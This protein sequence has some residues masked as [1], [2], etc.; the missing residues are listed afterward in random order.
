MI[1]LVSSEEEEEI[2]PCKRRRMVN[3]LSK[4]NW[5]N[6]ELDVIVGIDPAPRN[7][8][9]CKYSVSKDEI[10]DWDWVDFQGVLKTV[11]SAQK[12]VDRLDQYID[13]HPEFFAKA[14]L[15]M[16]ERQIVINAKNIR[17]QRHLMQRFPRKCFDT[18]PKKI[19]SVMDQWMAM[20]TAAYGKKKKT[21][22]DLGMSVI[23]PKEQRLL[24]ELK[25]GRRDLQARVTEHDKKMI[26]QGRTK[27]KKP[28]RI[29][30]QPADAFDAL[31]IA[32]C[33]ACELLD[34]DIVGKRIERK[35]RRETLI[36]WVV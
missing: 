5:T 31:M 12:I 23:T 35:Q 24:D 2:K 20:P 7:F 16:V 13:D 28:R 21:T 26:S 30:V 11:P 32:L 25:R 34:R 4:E 6:G 33:M 15:I 22:V 1:N 27:L 10:T 17:V 18:D 9:V 3:P 19:K 29:K 14:D 36:H 8:S